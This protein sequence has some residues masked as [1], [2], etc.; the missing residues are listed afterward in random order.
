MK[1]ILD[2]VLY[3][4]KLVHFKVADTVISSLW[5]KKVW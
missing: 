4:Y 1:E 3:T 5:L 2:F